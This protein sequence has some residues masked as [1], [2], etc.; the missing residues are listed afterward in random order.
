M[1]AQVQIQIV[2]EKPKIKPS[3]LPVNQ[4]ETKVEIRP[5]MRAD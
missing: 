5:V 4:F 1:K 3:Q 2:K